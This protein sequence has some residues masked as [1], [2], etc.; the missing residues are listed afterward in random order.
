MAHYAFLDEN[1]IVVDVIKGI[2]ED[3]LIDGISPEEWYGNFK[4]L[5][6]IRTSYNSN[7]RKNHAGVGY[8]YDEDR[9]AFIPPRPAPY[10]SFDEENCRWIEPLNYPQDGNYYDWDIENA[11]WILKDPPM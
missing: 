1:N 7:I 4:G 11:T 9:D 10:Y 6:C 3:Q 8:Y 5:R 2:D